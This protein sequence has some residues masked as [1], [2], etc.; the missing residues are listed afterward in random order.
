LPERRKHAS[1][2]GRDS[3]AARRTATRDDN[4]APSARPFWSGTLTFGLVSIPVDLYS[5]SR[6]RAKGMRMVDK[7]GHPLGRQYRCPRDG[8]VLSTQDLVR[9]YETAGGQMVTFTD[10]ELESVAPEAS[11]DIELQ[12]FVPLSQI[13]PLYFDRPYFLAPAGRSAKAY[14]LL[15]RTMERTQRVAIGT[16]VMRDHEYLAAILSDNGVLRAHT[17]RRAD[18]IRTPHAIGLPERTAAPSQQVRAA[19]QAI[20]RLTREALDMSELEDRETAALEQLAQDKQR[21][22]QDL[23]EEP[24]L[25]AD[26]TED[27]GAQ[28]IDLMDVLRKTLSKN[29]MVDTA[30]EAPG[31]TGAGARPMRAQAPRRAPA[32]ASRAP[33]GGEG[34]RPTRTD[35]RLA[36]ASKRELY[37]RASDLHIPGRSQMDKA[38]L[39]AA[40]RRAR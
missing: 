14:N 3:A 34:S 35:A 15:A 36:H 5:A 20:E 17:L 38:E 21:R 10:E 9:G 32:R 24:A 30:D 22:G 12:R 28:I 33:A 16:F 13:P 26:E 19:A 37:K 4:A 40:I 25:A 11:R 18:E 8:Q 39:L 29:A 7:E 31:R 6:P 23:I 1:R 27:G 2:K